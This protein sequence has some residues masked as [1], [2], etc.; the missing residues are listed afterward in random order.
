M[1]KISL[2]QNIINLNRVK[3]VAHLR[4]LILVCY[5]YF[6]RVLTLFHAVEEPATYLLDLAILNY[7]YSLILQYWHGR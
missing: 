4:A 5:T 3:L 6:I 7:T 1:S 2:F